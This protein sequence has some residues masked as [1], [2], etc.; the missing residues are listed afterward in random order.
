[1]GSDRTSRCGFFDIVENARG[2]EFLQS[3]ETLIIA[4]YLFA[5]EK[6]ERK[7]CHE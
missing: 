2:K 3:T 4:L 5:P 6:S 7:K 1:M